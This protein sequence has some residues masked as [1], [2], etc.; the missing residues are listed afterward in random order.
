MDGANAAGEEWRWFKMVLNQDWNAVVYS[1][2]NQCISFFSSSISFTPLYL[3]SMLIFNTF[4]GFRV[5]SY[6]LIKDHN[7]ICFFSFSFIY[8]SFLSF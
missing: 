3:P 8:F 6:N 5:G 7:F 1:C 4:L 2:S